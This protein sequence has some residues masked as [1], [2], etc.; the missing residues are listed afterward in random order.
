MYELSVP[1]PQ[2]RSN[3]SDLYHAGIKIMFAV[4]LGEWS[5]GRCCLYKAR[6]WRIMYHPIKTKDAVNL[7]LGKPWLMAYC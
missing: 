7:C 6:N 3:N 4:D 5:I 1:K 2:M